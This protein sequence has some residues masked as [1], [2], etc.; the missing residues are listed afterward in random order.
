MEASR[1]AVYAGTFEHNFDAKGRVTVPS[2]WRSDAHEDVLHVFPDR[3]CLRVYPASFL[4]G[5]RDQLAGAPVKDPRR[6]V[7]ERLAN[8]IQPASPD[9]QGRI[10]IRKSLRDRASLERE[11]VLAGSLDHFQIWDRKAWNKRGLDDFDF[12]RAASEV[13]W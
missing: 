3:E 13:G 7:L 1:K 8:T 12:E 10:I 2:E 4:E 9:G 11:V 6:A 5:K